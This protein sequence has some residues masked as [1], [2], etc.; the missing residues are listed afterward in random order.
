MEFRLLK[1]KINVYIYEQLCKCKT[2]HDRNEKTII[3][4]HAML[5]Q[6]NGLELC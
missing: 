2:C 4:N 3:S 5:T 1:E 6:Q